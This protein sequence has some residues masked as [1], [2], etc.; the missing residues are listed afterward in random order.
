M[1]KAQHSRHL[2]GWNA[3]ELVGFQCELLHSNDRLLISNGGF[4]LK[5][6]GERKPAEWNRISSGGVLL[7]I[8]QNQLAKLERGLVWPPEV[9]SRPGVVDEEY[10][11]L[12]DFGVRLVAYVPSNVLLG[13][14][15][16]FISAE[17][18]DL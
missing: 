12:Q 6:F 11:N 16:P 7:C 14:R 13:P 15:L 2:L 3:T 4:V 5:A 10:L 8:A 1:M 18:R 9:R 17:V